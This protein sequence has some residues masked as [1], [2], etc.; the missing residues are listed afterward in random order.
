MTQLR[1]NRPRMLKG[2]ARQVS[3]IH[4][5]T[6]K[7]MLTQECVDFFNEFALG[8]IFS[9]IYFIIRMQTYSSIIKKGTGTEQVIFFVN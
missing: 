8:L 2:L 3:R 6:G 4:S 5:C 1:W 9:T 7:V